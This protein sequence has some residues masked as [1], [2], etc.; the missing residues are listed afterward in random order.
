[1]LY[2]LVDRYQYV[3][4]K[5]AFTLQREEIIIFI[6]TAVRTSNMVRNPETSVT[7]A[8]LQILHYIL[9]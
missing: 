3:G 8:I 1:M 2:N 5:C 7:P 6:V 9:F 4:G